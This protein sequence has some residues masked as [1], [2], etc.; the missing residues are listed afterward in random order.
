MGSG[1]GQRPGRLPEPI[2]AASS[3]PALQLQELDV[4]LIVR[5]ART[6][7]RN[8]IDASMVDELHEVC[9][10]VE[11]DPTIV[12][13]TGQE[14][15][16]AAGADIA[17]LR[18]RGRADALRGIN[19]GLFER[20]ARLPLPTIAAING[21]AIGGG[22]ELAY[23]CDF[24]VATPLARFAHPEVRLG[25]MPAAGAC[26]R[27]RELVGLPLA[28]R[29]VLAGAALGAQEALVAGLVDEMVEPERLMGTALGLAKRIARA[30]PLALQLTKLALAAPV[31]A[32]PRVDDL[33]QAVLF[34]TAEKR[35]RMDD[36]LAG[37]EAAQ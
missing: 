13:L 20:I 32:H 23:A 22:A 12:I 3:R 31:G 15:I 27:L 5:L 8:A 37:R 29:M 36:F 21:P 35:Q 11:R 34:E 14:G 33:A 4:A 18:D 16:F 7:K 19:S 10:K 30:V 28:R 6:E 1:S 17:E 2:D 26:W 25:I 24:R 9:R